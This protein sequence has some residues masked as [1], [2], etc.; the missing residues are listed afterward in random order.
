M[1]Q[2]KY[3]D[4]TKPHVTTMEQHYCLVCCKAFDT[5]AILFDTHLRQRFARNTVTGWGLCEEHKKLYYEGYIAL[6]EAA[7]LAAVGDPA[8][9]ETPRT[10]RIMHIKEHTFKHIFTGIEPRAA[11]GKMIPMCFLEKEAFEKVKEAFEKVMG[12][13][14]KEES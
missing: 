11:N 1:K 2:V 8:P 4:P 12:M 9:E 7:D 3:N 5:G 10:G 13:I 14:P 6:V